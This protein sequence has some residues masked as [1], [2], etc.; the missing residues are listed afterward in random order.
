M[1]GLISKKLDQLRIII[2]LCSPTE[3]YLDPNG[4]YPDT[5]DSEAEDVDT[6]N[7]G[8]TPDWAAG[9]GAPRNT[10]TASTLRLDSRMSSVGSSGTRSTSRLSTS[11][12]TKS[13]KSGKKKNTSSKSRL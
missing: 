7:L 10:M 5:T 2:D 11:K 12:S 6:G 3:S 1:F 8:L 4:S 9:L 13:N